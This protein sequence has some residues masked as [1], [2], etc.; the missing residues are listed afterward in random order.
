MTQTAVLNQNSM[1]MA[2]PELQNPLALSG[3]LDEYKS[4]DLTPTIGQ[5][6]PDANLV[7]WINSENADALLRDLA[8]TISQRGVVVF[9]AQNELTNDLQKRLILKL[10]ELTGAPRTSSLHIH[11]VRNNE[12]TLGGK[13]AQISTISSLQTKNIYTA[14]EKDRATMKKANGEGWHSDVA[15]EPVPA[16]YTS[17]RLT[18]LPRTGGDT[19]WA[20]GYEVYDRISPQ[21][22]KFLETLTVKFHQPFFKEMAEKGKFDMYLGPRGAPQNIGPELKAVHPVVRTNPVTGWK[23]VFAVGPAAER[24]NEVTDE[25]SKRLLDWFLDMVWRNH[26][27]QVRLKWKNKNDIAIWDNRS[28]FHTATFDYM[29]YGERFGNRAVGIGEVAYF[30]PSSCSRREALGLPSANY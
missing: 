8:I 20:S 29:G 25:E 23:S 2:E 15:Y 4:F 18:E 22:Q 12:R 13:D 3:I 19:L 14:I 17:L 7:E 21:Y 28:V 26:D 24:I 9:R 6:F 5:E 1:T 30:D 27:L 11:P 16:S 10:G